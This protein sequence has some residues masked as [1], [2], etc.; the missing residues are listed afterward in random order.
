MLHLKGRETEVAGLIEA[1]R[2]EVDRQV[3]HMRLQS[4]GVD[5]RWLR[6]ERRDKG[7]GEQR[8]AARHSAKQHDAGRQKELGSPSHDGYFPASTFTR[9]FGIS[10]NISG[11]YIASTRLGGSAKS[12]TLFRRTVYSILTTPLGR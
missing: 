10:P 2:M 5:L 8:K 4:F 6:P 1:A 9:P 7:L 11:A 12:P 3:P